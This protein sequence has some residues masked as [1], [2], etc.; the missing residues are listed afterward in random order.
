MG[1]KETLNLVL[2][3]EGYSDS[4]RKM[5]HFRCYASMVQ[6]GTEKRGTAMYNIRSYRTSDTYP[7]I[8]IYTQKGQGKYTIVQEKIHNF[9]VNHSLHMSLMAY[10][11]P[12]F[13]HSSL[14][15][16]FRALK[17]K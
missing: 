12:S 14:I 13:I 7:Q 10:T 2:V 17:W 9:G 15:K 8:R 1:A 6:S 5:S 4:S 3:L 11:T 16:A